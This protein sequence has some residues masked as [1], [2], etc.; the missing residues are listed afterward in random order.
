M[1]CSF[2]YSCAVKKSDFVS[3]HIAHCF[4]F[5]F[6]P[7][8]WSAP[9][10]PCCRCRF[11]THVVAAIPVIALM[12]AAAYSCVPLLR[13]EFSSVLLLFNQSLLN[14]KPWKSPSLYLLRVSGRVTENPFYH[15]CPPL[16]FGPSIFS[17][18]LLLP[19]MVTRRPFVTYSLSQLAYRVSSFARPP[20]SSLKAVSCPAVRTYILT[21]LLRPTRY[22]ALSL[23]QFP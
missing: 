10:F 1:I 19:R 21:H 2:L 12:F 4:F 16:A 20:Y 5:C 11:Q 3:L 14:P 13:I 18:T 6:F 17:A 15:M 9:V 22:H 8:G 23:H 7:A